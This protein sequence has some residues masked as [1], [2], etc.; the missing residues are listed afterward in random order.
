MKKCFALAIGLLLVCMF[1]VP[2]LAV[3]F[4]VTP[5]EKSENFKITYDDMDDTGEIT[6]V[7]AE[8]N[9]S[10]GITEED[11]AGVVLLSTD[12]KLIENIPPLIR[13]A[14]WYSGEDWISANKII[15]KPANTRYTFDA[16]NG[17]VYTEVSD[18]RIVEQYVLVLTDESIQMLKDIVENELPTV[19]CRLSGDRSVDVEVMFSSE[20]RDAIKELYTL[21]EESGAL[22]NDFSLVKQTY[23]C[24][25]KEF[26]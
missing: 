9:I 3:N 17:P 19:K 5:F 11:N 16:N 1:T 2:A 4:D 12:I 21:Y 6:F 25:I 13:V 8:K 24:A 7:E 15:I 22:D 20:Q 26:N 18:G 23:P 10:L 14:V